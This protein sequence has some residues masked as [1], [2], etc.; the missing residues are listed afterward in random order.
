MQG[1]SYQKK[2]IKNKS[3]L[4]V[5]LARL[6]L[7][8]KDKNKI[9]MWMFVNDDTRIIMFTNNIIHSLFCTMTVYALGN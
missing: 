3:T 7:Q 2:K 1:H 6:H 5:S 8:K 4:K 9:L